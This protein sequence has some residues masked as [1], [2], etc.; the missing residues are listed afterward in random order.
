MN[1]L[2]DIHIMS[3]NIIN[4]YFKNEQHALVLHHIQSYNEFI[5]KLRNMN[6][7]LRNLIF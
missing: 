7:S 2:M 4:K 6:D 3:W 1:S 5:N